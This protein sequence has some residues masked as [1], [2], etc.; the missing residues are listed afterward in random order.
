[1]A[2]EKPEYRHFFVVDSNN[3]RVGAFDLESQ[4]EIE[5]PDDFALEPIPLPDDAVG[6]DQA[7]Q[8]LTNTTVDWDDR[9]IER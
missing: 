4:R 3:N 6:R 5:L 9:L 2:R 8:Q 7:L 1:M